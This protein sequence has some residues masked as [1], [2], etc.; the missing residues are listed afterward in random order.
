[1]S[2]PRRVAHAA[3]HHVIHHHACQSEG[4]RGLVAGE[5]A[6]LPQ[7]LKVG[8]DVRVDSPDSAAEHGA[9]G[10]AQPVQGWVVVGQCVGDPAG[11]LP[12]EPRRSDVT[13][14]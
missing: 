9:G 3:L 11:T 2:L 12:T 1:M 14:G 5:R 7:L 10:D 4:Q 6:Q 13:V 8:A